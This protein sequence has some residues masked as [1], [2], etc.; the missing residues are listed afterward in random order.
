M[1]VNTH[2][3]SVPS[4]IPGRV[5][6]SGLTHCYKDA[7]TGS[8]QFTPE[9]E[10]HESKDQLPGLALAIKHPIAHFLDKADQLPDLVELLDQLTLTSEQQTDRKTLVKSSLSGEKID[11]ATSP[12]YCS[13]QRVQ[14]VETRIYLSESQVFSEDYTAAT[15]NPMIFYRVKS[16][17]KVDYERLPPINIAKFYAQSGAEEEQ[18]KITVKKISMTA[19]SGHGYLSAI[20]DKEAHRDFSSLTQFTGEEDRQLLRQID[21][22]IAEEIKDSKEVSQLTVNDFDLKKFKFKNEKLKEMSRRL[23]SMR[24]NLFLKF[25]KQFISAS[26]T[27]NYDGKVKSGS[28]AFYFL[29]NKSLALASVVDKILEKKIGELINGPRP[30][31]NLNNGYGSSRQPTLSS[32]GRG[33]GRPGAYAAP[34]G[35]LGNNYPQNTNI[36]VG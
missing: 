27:I 26:T 6:P 7:T 22:Y 13:V 8:W 5:T 18:I 31:T 15:M 30:G 25:T 4:I 32:R 17:A 35:R 14:G 20:T 1:F 33:M 16:Q 29:K 36:S 2:I 24:T 12:L 28:L 11:D 34:T 3:G 10:Y 9:D 23:L 21:K 19:H